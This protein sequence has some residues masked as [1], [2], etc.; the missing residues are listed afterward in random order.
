MAPSDLQDDQLPITRRLPVL[1]VLLAIPASSRLALLALGSS[2]SRLSLYNLRAT[3]LCACFAKATSLGKVQP[4][5][6]MGA[7]TSLGAMTAQGDVP[8]PLPPRC[9]L[10]EAPFFDWPR[11][12]C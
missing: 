8:A 6:V 2:I 7:L 12:G 9:P 1:T 3:D 10:L 11:S 5:D 4:L